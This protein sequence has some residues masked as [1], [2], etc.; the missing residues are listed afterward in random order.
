MADYPQAG[1]PHDYD[2]EKK[3]VVDN[4][5]EDDGVS[6]RRKFDTERDDGERAGGAKDKDKGDITKVNCYRYE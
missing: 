1:I 2:N 5:E 3:R 4:G 6:K